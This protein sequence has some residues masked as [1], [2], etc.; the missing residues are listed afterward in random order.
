MAQAYIS[1]TYPQKY[2]DTAAKF[3]DKTDLKTHSQ[4]WLSQ[5]RLKTSKT[6]EILTY[7]F[8]DR[9][10]ISSIAFDIYQVGAYYEL[11]YYDSDNV[12]LPLLRDDYNQIKFTVE[13][14]AD[15]TQWMH[16]QFECLPC[17]ATKLEIRMQRVD[18]DLAPDEEYSL[19]LRK[20]AIK[21]S[22]VK[23]EDAALP[24]KP[25]ADILGN[26]ISKSVRDWQASAVIDGDEYTFWKSEP[27]ISQDAVVC[28]Y[29]DIRDK[30]GQAQYFDSIDI[31]PIYIGSQMNVYWSSDDAEGER[32]AAFDAYDSQFDDIDY[33][34]ES[35]KTDSKSEDGGWVFD[36]KTSI[37][38]FDNEAARFGKTRSWMI[39]MSWLP[40]S[41]D[42]SSTKTIATL[43][44]N[45]YVKL[46]GKVLQFWY[47]DSNG[48]K[49]IDMQLPADP[50][51]VRD[52]NPKN[53]FDS[54]VRLAFGVDKTDKPSIS[55]SARVINKDANGDVV[56]DKSSTKRF[57]TGCEL[58]NIASGLDRNFQLSE[59]AV[60]AGIKTISSNEEI[61]VPAHTSYSVPLS[62][63]S[64]LIDSKATGNSYD[65]DVKVSY[66]TSEN[67]LTGAR[68]AIPD[69]SDDM[70]MISWW[71]GPEDA[72]PS[73]LVIDS[74]K[75]YVNWFQNPKLAQ[76]G[77]WKPEQIDGNGSAK[78]QNNKL[79]LTGKVR[80]RNLTK[81]P[82]ELPGG[83]AY[84]FSAVPE[85]DASVTSWYKSY[86]LFVY[87]GKTER[88][89]SLNDLDLKSGQRASIT[90][91]APDD[92]RLLSFGFVGCNQD[93]KTVTWSDPMLCESSDWEKM[94]ADSIEWF[95][96]DYSRLTSEEMLRYCDELNLN[97]NNDT[98][99]PLLGNVMFPN[100]G[101][102]STWG[103]PRPFDGNSVEM[104]GGLNYY[105]DVDDWIYIKGGSSF[106]ISFYSISKNGHSKLQPCIVDKNGN[107]YY[108]DRY[109]TTEK[110]GGWWLTFARI[111][112]PNNHEQ[113]YAHFAINERMPTAHSYIA[114]LHIYSNS[115]AFETPA[116]HSVTA[117]SK[118]FN[119]KMTVNDL[120]NKCVEI[121]NSS[122]ADIYVSSCSVKASACKIADVA[123][124][125]MS[126]SS[127][128]GILQNYVFK[129]EAPAILD[130]DKFL[131]N[132]RRYVSPD[133]YDMSSTLS[134]ALIYGR[135]REEQVLRGG[136]SDSMYEA[137]TWTPVLSGQKLEKMRYTIP[138]PTKA[139][140][141]KLEFTQLTAVQYPIESSGIQSSYKT[142]PTDAAVEMLNAA[143]L[144]ASTTNDKQNNVARSTKV[145]SDTKQKYYSS[146]DRDSIS[147][148]E[149]KKSLYEDPNINVSEPKSTRWF[150]NIDSNDVYSSIASE[151]TSSVTYT[152]PV[153]N[154][155]NLSNQY[156]SRLSQ[157]SQIN[158][159]YAIYTAQA[160]ETLLSIANEFGISDW[161]TIYDANEYVDD[162][163]NQTS[164][165]AR[166]PGYWL[167]Q[168]QQIRIPVSQLRQILGN[169]KLDVVK[170][171]SIKA[172]QT[173]IS[174]ART[175]KPTTNV[176]GPLYFSKPCRHYYED[177]KAERTQSIAYFVAIRELKVQIVDYLSEKDNVSWNFY[178][179]AMPLWH[180]TGGYLTDQEVFVPDFST[181]AEIA[182]A[183]TDLM[184]C[185]S[186]YRTVKLISVNRDS[187][188]NRTYFPFDG[189]P[190]HGTEYW[191]LHPE[192]NCVWDDS[193][194]NDPTVTEDNG[195]AWNSNRFA[196]GDTWDG[197]T[198]SGKDW[199]VWYDGELVKHIVVN[200][201]DRVFDANGKQQP[202]RF[203]LGEIFVPN[204]SL[205]T[206]GVS[207]FSL[208]LA[209]PSN[210]NQKLKTRIKLVSGRYSNS[211]LI[212][213][214]IGYDDTK[215]NVWQDFH[216]SRHRLLDMQYKCKVWLEFNDFEKLDLYF[217]SAYIETGTMR[218]LM[219]N[220][221][222]L[223]Y[224]DVTS[225]V[226]RLD[227][228]YTFLTASNDLQLKVEM[229]DPQDWF[230]QI[231]VV[232]VYIPEEDAVA[233]SSDYF[234]KME[235]VQKDGS[236]LPNS[237]RVG[238]TFPLGCKV[239]YSSG[240]TKMLD[241]KDVAF[242][243]DSP[244]TVMFQK[245]DGGMQ[246]RC[247]K[248]GRCRIMFSSNGQTSSGL[249]F[250]VQA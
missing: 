9:S 69:S 153:L 129:Q 43:G 102:D 163:S 50:K 139:K 120:N 167:M 17:V 199:S 73:N 160:S 87:D 206:L 95:D 218:I 134:N 241:L 48:M 28:L 26:T 133:S 113:G 108:T 243:T 123:G 86:K 231:I 144:D 165:P 29:V 83:K 38:S 15:W 64:A 104:L 142:F 42:M 214:E 55:I 175:Q 3:K 107:E 164:V 215:M 67:Y 25:N 141:L 89:L 161:K 184:H 62:D 230:T 35:S 105:K 90:F 68:I 126:I 1:D 117:M 194:P 91:T 191:K 20:L 158:S 37:M 57:S 71:T 208:D 210:P 88:F 244:E 99:K 202:Y 157:L 174:D 2:F 112:I 190:W 150:P 16:W 82:F 205:T 227:S 149:D 130:K 179:M 46:A 131:Q 229:Y 176:T 98:S 74:K 154:S 201:E 109:T 217:K 189:T 216:T 39:A 180:L 84:V 40:K 21:R 110:T 41:S 60:K 224:E 122:D 34:I 32:K 195:G 152:G 61:L 27:Q 132:P 212:D 221:Q 31:D 170:K 140:F 137:K 211:Y 166:I 169:A 238:A 79:V 177:K 66:R 59:D 136:V 237:A 80:T 219:K 58:S 228:E 33:K 178:S 22:I 146:I 101:K 225:A 222:S 30:Y 248:A 181:G 125:D 236:N 106:T 118:T 100:G 52:K 247:L 14:K 249:A 173:T 203:L 168:G 85:F 232:P 127:I 220:N 121:I 44:K 11:W 92:A 250:E 192:L 13:S 207:L 204:N 45:F 75:A 242:R 63:A 155:M 226:G 93:G 145:M 51:Y 135:F 65:I 183:E 76:A 6:V 18:D 70:K 148:Y 36:K 96:G 193:T 198:I 159:Q 182:E 240:I 213:E 94:K 81:F 209:N 162:S 72:S 196:W 8:A 151:T 143:E 233:L 200:P 24:L 223:D 235:L 171:T 156:D 54:E 234:I 49:H 186:Y 245:I 172:P 97:P 5:P 138:N 197:T 185:Q 56:E 116:K 77:A 187:L 114:D 47:A 246:L 147:Q 239:Q 12:K 4:E 128:D 103:K 78:L 111:T 124:S 115:L 119:T 23:R 7:T 19:A 53:N 10:P 188:T